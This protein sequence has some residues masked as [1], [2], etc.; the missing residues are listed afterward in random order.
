M[1][2]RKTFFELGIHHAVFKHATYLCLMRAIFFAKPSWTIATVKA[3]KG[4]KWVYIHEI[5]QFLRTRNYLIYFFIILIL[6]SNHRSLRLSKT[7]C[8]FNNVGAFSSH[9]EVY[10]PNKPHNYCM[11]GRSSFR[12]N[13]NTF[14][15][16]LKRI[17]INNKVN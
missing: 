1:F 12:N 16:P 8:I 13:F 15:L 4:L 6:K 7:I 5:S 14:K 2:F 10:I 3:L 9:F 17:K 11:T